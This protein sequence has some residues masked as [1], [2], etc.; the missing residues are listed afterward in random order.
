[1]ELSAAGPESDN[2]RGASVPLMGMK[3]GEEESQTET[4]EIYTYYSF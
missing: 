4:E 2:S 1:M 3:S